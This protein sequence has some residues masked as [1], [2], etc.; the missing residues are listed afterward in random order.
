MQVTPPERKL[1]DGEGLLEIFLIPDVA[2]AADCLSLTTPD[3]TWDQ[4]L[5]IWRPYC[6][7][8]IELCRT[9]KKISDNSVAFKVAQVR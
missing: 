2:G 8:F 5:K 7:A 3:K 1:R 6:F 9:P 4:R